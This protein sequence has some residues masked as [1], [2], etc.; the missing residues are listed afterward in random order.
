MTVRPDGPSGRTALTQVGRRAPAGSASTSVNKISSSES[1]DNRNSI[2]HTATQ[3]PE[4]R[5]S[6]VRTV[7]SRRA[8]HPQQAVNYVSTTPD[9]DTI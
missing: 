7:A 4:N 5:K 9:S 6:T 1:A 3:P 8:C 2:D